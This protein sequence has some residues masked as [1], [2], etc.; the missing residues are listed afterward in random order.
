MNTDYFKKP[1]VKFLVKFLSLMLIWEI[2]Y[3]LF[4]EKS[5]IVDTY[6]TRKVAELCVSILKPW[7][8]ISTSLHVSGLQNV[9][10]ND[11]FWL[12]ITHSCNGLILMVLFSV[13]LISFTGDAI[14][15][16]ITIVIGIFSIYL[17]NVLRVAS[18]F[19]VKIYAPKYLDFSHHWLFTAIVYGFVFGIWM[20]WINKLSKIKLINK[21]NAE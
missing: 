13:F 8:N 4:L 1:L 2:T 10:Y 14:L 9:Y 12:R 18:L 7:Y 20:L 17:I 16:A 19:L 6:L 21:S 15:K 3:S 5:R 11:V